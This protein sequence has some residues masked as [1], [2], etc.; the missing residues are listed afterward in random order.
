MIDRELWLKNNALEQI[1]W[2]KNLTY[3]DK[4]TNSNKPTQQA[5]NPRS[6]DQALQI[7]KNQLNYI[8]SNNR[9]R[10][11]KFI[12]SYLIKNYL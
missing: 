4:E 10:K 1:E 3:F 2:E 5:L 11:L 9:R 8:I 6:L 12:I 7:A